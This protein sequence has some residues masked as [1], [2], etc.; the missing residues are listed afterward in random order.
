MGTNKLKL[1]GG[2]VLVFFLGALIGS[3]G[4]RIY[5][6]QRFAHYSK[7]G[8]EAKKNLLMKKLS[9]ELDLT[10]S[11]KAE[12]EKIVEN[13]MMEIRDFRKESRAQLEKIFNRKIVLIK[14][15]LN[16][17]QGG[18]LDKLYNKFKSRRRSKPHFRSRGSR[19]AG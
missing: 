17:E 3:L 4:T 12:I 5:F 16:D 14:N 7:G 1:Y 9:A 15:K 11:Q 19:D 6:K 2:I 10:Q 18:E 8:P 13:S